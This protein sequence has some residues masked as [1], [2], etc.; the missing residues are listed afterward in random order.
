MQRSTELMRETLGEHIHDFL[1]AEKRKEWDAYQHHVSAWEH[2][3]Y[4]GVL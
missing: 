1:V 3:K 4:L 2:D